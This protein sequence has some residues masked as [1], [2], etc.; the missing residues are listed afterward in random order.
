MN[1]LPSVIQRFNWVDIFVII[2]LF[3]ICYIAFKTGFVP[4]FFKLLGTLL[5]I[6][7]AM[8]YYTG[9]SDF[10][11]G[12]F[13]LD[14]KMPLDFLDFICFISLAIISYLVGILFRQA[15]CR[16][17]KLETV[18]RLNMWGGFVIGIAR[19]VLLAGLF[20][21]IISISTVKYLHDKVADSYFGV[22]LIKVAPQTYS[23]VWYGFMSKF[24]PAEKFN[25]TIL[26]VQNNFNQ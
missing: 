6:Y 2:L 15:F 13:G 1:S 22:S 25:K 12:R 16:L 5:A 14:K 17:I 19:A 11:G 8:H 3:R 26:E 7:V 21:F 23:S 18:P 10:L 9:L 4:E 24:T 20:T